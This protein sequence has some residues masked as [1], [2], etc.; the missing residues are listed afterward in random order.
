[1]RHGIRGALPSLQSAT[2]RGQQI[3][4]AL[5]TPPGRNARKPA[6]V[7]KTVA[8]LLHA[9]TPGRPDPDIPERPRRRAQTG[10]RPLLRHRRVIAPGGAAGPGGDAPTPRPDAA[11]HGGGRAPL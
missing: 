2:A 3:L 9:A 5:R 10:H 4:P 8:A 11:A 1:M 6:R 7:A